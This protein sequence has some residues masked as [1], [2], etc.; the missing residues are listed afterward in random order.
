MFKPCL[1][2]KPMVSSI[3]VV[4]FESKTLKNGEHPIMLRLT[5]D[6]KTKYISLGASC[7]K[8]L[9]NYQENVPKPKHPLHRELLNKINK[10]KLEASK[11][12][13]ALDDDEK[14][15]SA[16]LLQNRL[17]KT[18][19][20]KTVLQYFDEVIDRLEK[21]DRIGYANTFA[22]TRSSLKKFRESRDFEFSDITMNFITQFEEQF[23]ARGCGLN[24]VFVHLRTF[25]T[26]INYAKKDEIIK[27]DF[28]PFKNISFTK[29]RRVK[30]AKRAI[31]KSEMQAIISL[32]LEKGTSI[33][34]ARN[35]FLFSFYNRGINF[36]DIAFLKID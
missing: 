18:K 7:S 19:V 35:Y 23:Y 15:Y 26:L 28:D 17:K 36:I 29:F 14:D 3:K 8:E 27:Q 22:S 31:S 21:A 34:D 10:K 24:S 12:L 32:D 20:K 4:L 25:K 6:R 13:L 9:W 33:Y 5:K 16:E 30:T 11:L 1:N 2:Q